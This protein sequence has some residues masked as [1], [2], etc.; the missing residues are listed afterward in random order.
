MNV[1]IF[2]KSNQ[3]NQVTLFVNVSNWIV[4]VNAHFISVDTEEESSMMQLMGFSSFDTTKVNNFKF[5]DF[6]LYIQLL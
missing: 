2:V 4:F 3:C 1:S 6:I 5:P